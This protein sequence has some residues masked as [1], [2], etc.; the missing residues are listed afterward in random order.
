MI[1]TKM[2]KYL[3]F[4]CVFS[5]LGCDLSSRQ[6]ADKLFLIPLIDQGTYN[7]KEPT[8]KFFL[9]Y[10]LEEISGLSY[11]KNG[12]L[13]CLQDEDGKVFFY[14]LNK[15]EITR[16]V[17]FAN[18]GDYEGLEM[19]GDTAYVV[20]SNGDLFKFSIDEKEVESELIKT[21]LNKDNDIEGLG[22]NANANKLILVCKDNSDIGKRKQ[23]GKAAFQIDLSN[24]QFDSTA[25][26]SITKYDMKRFFE[27]NKNK[28]Y[29]EKRINFRPSGIAW[30]PIQDKYYVLAHVGKMLLVVN[31]QGEIEASYPISPR[32]LGQPEGIC[33][34]PN[35]DMFISS[36]GE[37][38]KGYILKFEME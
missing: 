30:H 4:L 15:K 36:E 38:D 25:L 16:S 8:D 9:P 11:V 32:L 20:K 19:V 14:D 31:R 37:G 21:P 27:V 3:T 6:T 2:S 13:A 24:N 17:K 29:E 23:E 18:Q 34:A 35:G 5:L 28:A 10:V 22:Y 1:T 12:V 33:F 7:L 26:F